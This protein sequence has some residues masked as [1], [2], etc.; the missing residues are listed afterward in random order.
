MVR[1]YGRCPGGVEMKNLITCLVVC[2][3]SGTAVAQKPR[4]I[5]EKPDQTVIP[6]GYYEDQIFVRIHEGIDAQTAIS[7]MINQRDVNAIAEISGATWIM[8]TEDSQKDLVGE[9]LKYAESRLG[10]E[11]ADPRQ[12]LYLKLPLLASTARAIDVLNTSPLVEIAIPVPMLEPAS[13][14]PPDYQPIQGYENPAAYGGFNA[15]S[16][17]SAF[18]IHGEGV[19]VCDI[20]WDF[21]ANHCDFP[22]VQILGNAPLGNYLDH[23]TAVLGAMV[24]LNNGIGTTG[25][26]HGVDAVKF[27]SLDSNGVESAI[28]L[29]TNNMPAGSVILLEVQSSG[30][31]GEGAWVPV[32]WYEPRYNA[33]LYAVGNDM[34]VCEAAGNGSQDLDS[35]IYSKGNGGH[36]PFLPEND[37][38]AIMIGAGGAY[39][40]CGWSEGS[41][42]RLP[43]SNYG[44]RVDLQGWGEC[45]MTTGYGDAWDE[46]DC[47]YTS[48]FSGTS[49]ATPI[50]AGACLLI[51]SYA[52]NNLGGPLLPE[53]MRSLLIETGQAQVNPSTGHIGP[54]PDAYAAIN[55][56]VSVGA[57]CIE[58]T[59]AC[60]VV[61]ESNCNVGAG[62]YQGNDTACGDIDCFAPSCPSDINGD[63]TTDVSDLL[64]VIDQWGLTNSPADVNVDGIVDVSDL[65]IVIGNWGPCE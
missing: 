60:V 20:E 4:T 16:V 15:E 52:V 7:S 42:E 54:L 45:V 22:N 34:I 51:Q 43:Y 47:D 32:E 3:L 29:A 41:K 11:I 1:T 64:A 2:V 25:I 17:W 50:V 38:G 56:F 24:S 40:T 19:Q 53:E 6:S 18:D 46:L 10:R 59:Q 57:C 13:F 61:S 12:G 28:L 48:T 14:T 31:N 23:G 30:P 36:Y 44:S 5:L 62:I 39:G 33:V 8:L 26:A 58:A 21:N 63:N 9:K 37:S 55:T 49:S 27:A 35:S 65:L